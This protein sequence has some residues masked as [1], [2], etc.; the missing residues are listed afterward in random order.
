MEFIIYSVT[1]GEDVAHSNPSET[2]TLNEV[3]YL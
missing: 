3:I 1:E 2:Y